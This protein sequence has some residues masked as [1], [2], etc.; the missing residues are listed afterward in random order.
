MNTLRESKPGS[1]KYSAHDSLRPV[2]FYC[3]A[4]S[5]RSVRICGDFNHWSPLPM[6]RRLDGWW[7]I[8]LLLCHGHHRYR[9]LVDGLPV[10]DSA[11][12]GIG[13]DDHGDPVSLV[14]VS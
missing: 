8:S 10:L 6:Q 5:A 11:A 2:N 13:R 12:T 9:F 14:A 7:W 3:Q 1:G 4:P